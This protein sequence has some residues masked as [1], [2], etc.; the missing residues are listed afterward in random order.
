[1]GVEQQLTGYIYVYIYIVWRYEE[2]TDSPFLL[3]CPLSSASTTAS[4]I[5]L[6]HPTRQE[7]EQKTRYYSPA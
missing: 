6:P 4:A 1:M 3:L 2:T 5:L 7:T